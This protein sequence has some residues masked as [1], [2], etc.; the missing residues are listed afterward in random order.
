MWRSPFRCVDRTLVAQPSI[1]KSSTPCCAWNPLNKKV[2]RVWLFTP[3]A[4]LPVFLLGHCVLCASVSPIVKCVIRSAWHLRRLCKQKNSCWWEKWR[5]SFH[6]TRIVILYLKKHCDK[7]CFFEIFKGAMYYYKRGKFHIWRKLASRELAFVI[8]CCEPGWA[9]LSKNLAI[10]T[11]LGTRATCVLREQRDSK[12]Q[13]PREIS[14]CVTF[15]AEGDCGSIE[16]CHVQCGT[17]QIHWVT[18]LQAPLCVKKC[19]MPFDSKRPQ[20]SLSY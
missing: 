14:L 8:L 1:C 10:L 5:A 13:V 17:A 20:N 19:L 6:E 4:S 3:S 7:N 18:N 2:S 16:E 15:F 9:Y 11:K 12:L